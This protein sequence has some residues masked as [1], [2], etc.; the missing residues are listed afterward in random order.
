MGSRS[1]TLVTSRPCAILPCLW[2][3]P[4]LPLG[5]CASYIRS[6]LMTPVSLMQRQQ[7]LSYTEELNN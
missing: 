1:Q 5:V 4:V 2:Q 6:L 3:N 7:T